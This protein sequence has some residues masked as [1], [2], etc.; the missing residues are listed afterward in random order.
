MNE[1]FSILF[2]FLLSILIIKKFELFKSLQLSLKTVEKIKKIILTSD[3]E[4]LNKDLMKYSKKLFFNSTKQLI[5]F[6]TIFFLFLAFQ[7]INPN[8]KNSILSLPGVIKLSVI[9]FLYLIVCKK[10]V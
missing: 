1:N 7:F 5:I 4:S 9:S 2:F 10:N 6:S 3:E 8:F